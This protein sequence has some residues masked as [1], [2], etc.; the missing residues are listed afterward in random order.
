MRHLGGTR[1]RRKPVRK[2]IYGFAV[3]LMTFLA[4][5]APALANSNWGT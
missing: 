1:H 4:V 2:R 5:A 3:S